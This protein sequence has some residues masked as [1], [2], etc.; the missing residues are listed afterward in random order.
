MNIIDVKILCIN[1]KK[2]IRSLYFFGGLFYAK[3]Y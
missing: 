3:G 1:I 2:N